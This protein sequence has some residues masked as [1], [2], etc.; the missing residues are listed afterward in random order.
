MQLARGH[1]SNTDLISVYLLYVGASL[2]IKRAHLL[3]FERDS[4][5]RNISAHQETL[6]AVVHPWAH[7]NEFLCHFFHE[8][9]GVQRSPIFCPFMLRLRRADWVLHWA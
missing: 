7:V 8:W 5:A 6:A 4:P 3:P 9:E 1:V 2:S